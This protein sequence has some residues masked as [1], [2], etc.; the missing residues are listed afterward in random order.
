MRALIVSSFVAG[1]P[2]GG[3]HQQL[4]LARLGWD[5]ALAPTVVFGRS[6][7]HGGRGRATDPEHFAALLEDLGAAGWLDADLVITGHFSLP[8]QVEATAE[9][10]RRAPP[11]VLVVDPILGDAPKGLYVKPEVAEALEALLLPLADWT[12]PNAWE[13]AYLTD[14]EVAD[15][16]STR[17]AAGQLEPP[18]LVT[19]VPLGE[20]E[21]GLLCCEGASATLIAHPRLPRAPNGT[22]DLVAAVFGAALAQGR[23]PAGAAADAAGAVLDR[24]TPSHGALRIETLT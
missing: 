16:A 2:I 17:H 8:S 11:R 21:T 23:P 9:A 6:P 19:S 24:L 5:A 14:L 1:D 3:S 22:G 7:A 13:L 10:I 12:T 4:A 20:A 15:L 18:A